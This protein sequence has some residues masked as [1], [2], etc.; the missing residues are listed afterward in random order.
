MQNLQ[1]Q[2]DQMDELMIKFEGKKNLWQI[3]IFESNLIIMTN[4]L[5][6]TLLQS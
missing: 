5:L 3:R 4:E 6:A 2:T 1:T